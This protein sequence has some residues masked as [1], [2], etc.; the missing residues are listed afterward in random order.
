MTNCSA[1]FNIQGGMTS[2]A[3][4]LQNWEFIM[5]NA[6]TIDTGFIVLEHDLFQDTVDIATGYILPDAI[7]RGGFTIEPIAMCVNR[8][9][10]NSYIETNDNSSFPPPQGTGT[11]INPGDPPTVAN[12]SVA[13]VGALNATTTGTGSGPNNGAIES[14]HI[15]GAVVAFTILAGVLGNVLTVL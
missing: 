11:V 8:G 13:A 3:Q 9:L 7:A 15:S 14:L 4:V 12:P 1:D 5:G 6:T 2:A 10:A